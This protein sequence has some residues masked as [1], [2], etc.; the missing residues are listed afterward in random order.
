MDGTLNHIELL[1]HLADEFE[2]SMRTN[3]LFTVVPGIIC[4][5]G[6][7]FLHF[8]IATGMMIYYGSSIVGIIKTMM[9]LAYHQDDKPKQLPLHSAD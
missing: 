9:P 3:F 1:F 5:G 8:G 4:I 2:N 7:Y 6:V